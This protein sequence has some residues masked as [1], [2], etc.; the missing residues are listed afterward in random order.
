MSRGHIF[1]AALLW[2]II[3]LL[4]LYPLSILVMESVKIAA[5]GQWGLGNYLEF[6]HDTY[7]LKTFGNTLV[8]SSLVLLTTTVFGIPLAY[9]LARYRQFGKTVFTALPVSPIS[10]PALKRP[11]K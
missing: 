5:T 11:P 8:L 6:F 10:I 1:L 2:S 3:G 9:V 4:V 7:Y